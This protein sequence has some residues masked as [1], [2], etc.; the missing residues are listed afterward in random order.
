VHI[1]VH[2]SYHVVLRLVHERE[3]E[4]NAHRE[5]LKRFPGAVSAQFT[6]T[7]TAVVATVKP[8]LPVTVTA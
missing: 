2:H 8:L 4:R 1:S 6:I 5:V 3:S 7:V